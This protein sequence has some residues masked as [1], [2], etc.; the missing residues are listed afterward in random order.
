MIKNVMADSGNFNRLVSGLSLDERRNLLNKLKGQSTLS[1]EPLYEMPGEEAS[2]GGIEDQYARLPWYYR[3]WYAL[4]SLFRAKSP[5]KIFEDR[6][7]AS[8]GRRID[9]A[10]PGLYD[11]QKGLLLPA[12]Y[13]HL[14][15]LKEAVRFF[16]TALDASVNRDRGAF[17]AFLGSLEMGDIH[18]RLTEGTDP[19]SLEKQHPD[20]SDQ[21]LR[22]M[23]FRAM[24]DAI[25]RM[26]EEE[27]AAMYASARS[28]NSLKELSAFFF[29]RVLMAFGFD[30]SVNGHTCSAGIVRELLSSL[31]NIL[32]SL[33]TIPPLSLLESLFV[34]ILQE[35][36]GEAG[37]DINRELRGLLAKAEEALEAIRGFNRQVPLPLIIRCSARNLSLSPEEISGGEEW[38]VVYRDYWKRRIETLFA[39]Y[40]KNR[41]LEELRSSF[42]YFLKGTGL[43][44][45][46]NTQS[47]SN[48]DGL[49]VKCALAL[50]FLLTFY[51]VVFMPDIN[52]VLRPIL[53][54]GEF[55]RKENRAEFTESYNNL[56]KL[57]DE[58]KK[59]DLELSPSGDYGKR[60][61]QARQD[62]SSLPVKRRK[63]QIV[64]D[65]AAADGERIL[66]GARAA[67][68]S[69]INI[70]GG[71][72]GREARAKYDSLSNLAKLA[73]KSG[74][75]LTA[76]DEAV[77]SFHKALKL[78]DDIELA[79][80]G[81]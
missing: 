67:S 18:R 73:G 2:E 80:L 26:S 6:Q 1:D 14:E 81:R 30:A 10:A 12:F 42:R 37:F 9:E 4:L 50:S 28:L 64:V 58:I 24:D 53:I 35:R 38:F 8:L 51:S 52:K 66:E 16:Y 54:E 32:A 74:Q 75:F 25:G 69:L 44:L 17:F 11:W 78:L 15:H 61:I 63:I 56:I 76:L 77:K 20:T 79:E 45:L 59:F 34:F 19:R 41:R 27:R 7:V 5:V 60:Y 65:E 43:K 48:P 13:R 47:D 68:Q 39:D 72:R 40:L 70:L 55:Q 22:Q 3:F 23:A 71:I 46:G 31:S 49:P 29:D 33:K 21:D 57:D 62:M 36:S